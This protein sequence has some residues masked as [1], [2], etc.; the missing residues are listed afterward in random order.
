MHQITL[1]PRIYFRFLLAFHA[2]DDQII[3]EADKADTSD[4]NPADYRDRYTATRI[5]AP[6]TVA[7]ATTLAR[8]ARATA[9]AR[10]STA[11]EP[12]PRII[13]HIF[14]FIFIAKQ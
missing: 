3:A 5:V 12:T 8:P 10:A 11:L 1:L 6:I 14:I 2:V 4:D 9:P 7:V 13:L